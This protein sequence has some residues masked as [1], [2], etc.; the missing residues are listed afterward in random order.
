MRPDSPVCCVS[1]TVVNVGDGVKGKGKGLKNVYMKENTY[2]QRRVLP[3]SE[4]SSCA[5]LIV[6]NLGSIEHAMWKP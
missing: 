1:F 3:R 2:R 6:C 5:M 4:E